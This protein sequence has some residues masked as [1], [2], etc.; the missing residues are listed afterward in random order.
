MKVQKRYQEELLEWKERLYQLRARYRDTPPGFHTSQEEA[1]VVK[2]LKWERQEYQ[3]QSCY[4]LGN[5]YRPTEECFV[6]RQSYL[7]RME[8]MIGRKNG[9]VIL[10]GIGGIGKTALA[11]EYIRR[12]AP[13]Y[14]TILFLPYNIGFQELICDDFQLPIE[15]LRYTTEKYEKKSRYFTEKLNILSQIA[16]KTKVLMVIDD[17]NR[18]RDARLRE[19]FSLPCDILVTTRMDPSYWGAYSGICV[20]ELETEEEWRQFIR[21]YHQG[22]FTPEE[23]KRVLDYRLR[24][25]GHTLLMQL[26]LRG[27]ETGVEMPEK[28]AKDFFSRFPLRKEEKQILRELSVMPVQGIPLALYREISQATSQALDC[29]AGYLLIGR[30]KKQEGSRAEEMISLHPVIAEAARRVYLPSI[31]NCRKMIGALSAK[32]WNAWNRT[33]Q[34]N[35]RLVPYVFAVLKAFPRPAA[36]MARQLDELVTLLWI[37]GYYEEAKVYS[38]K[39]VKS[40]TAY[41][42]EN[43]QITGE[44]SLR[45]AAVYYNSMDFTQADQWYWKAYH[46]LKECP[47]MDGRHDYLLST[48]LWKLARSHRYQGAYD[49]AL[50]LLDEAVLCMERFR[51]HTRIRE[52]PLQDGDWEI[53]YQYLLIDQAKCYLKQGKSRE[54]EENCRRG[55][56]EIQKR[57]DTSFRENEFNSLLV[58]IYLERGKLAE[59]EGLCRSLVKKAER[60]RGRN[61]K[62]TLSCRELLGDVYA[63]EGKSDKARR[64]Y[65]IV[66]ECLVREYPYQLQ[67]TE[68]IRRKRLQC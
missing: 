62:D 45:L 7:L 13:E 27:M 4:R 46:I 29:L 34:E 21:A 6:G 59:A 65:D 3:K 44:M 64:E 12:H 5:S 61:F 33:Y 48:A 63:A 25:K 50:K 67:W 37:Q 52:L 22:D 32:T 14:D 15:N 30:G 24:V 60:F 28:V 20:K 11:R 31:D 8:E 2:R 23:Q 18:R 19:V 1:Q 55:M 38:K 47:A 35:Q 51:D 58:E 68:K 42:G 54:A 49:T 41:Y 56:R 39:V 9:P 17:C 66:L 57:Q 53:E 10:Y 26:C 16:R 40:V 36:W 43:H